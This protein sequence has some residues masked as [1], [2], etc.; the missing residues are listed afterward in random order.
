MSD[1]KLPRRWC[2]PAAKKKGTNKLL[3]VGLVQTILHGLKDEVWVRGRP[4]QSGCQYSQAL[5]VE[6]LKAMSMICCGQRLTCASGARHATYAVFQGI[7][8]L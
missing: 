1:M 5:Q 8:R 4:C 7:L 6:D 2:R 3:A